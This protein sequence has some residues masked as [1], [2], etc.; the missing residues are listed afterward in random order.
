MLD[1]LRITEAIRAGA[2]PRM[3]V[4]IAGDLR[5][6]LSAGVLAS[7]DMVS[8]TRVTLEWGVSRET[9]AKSLRALERDGL[10][11]RYPGLGYYVRY[12]QA[13]GGERQTPR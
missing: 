11:T 7:G 13:T 1:S 2:D 8:I 6:K 9:A 3:Y 12:P 5:E 10:L 4:R